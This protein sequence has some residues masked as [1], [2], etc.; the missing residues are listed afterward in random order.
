[1]CK[2]H[3]FEKLRRLFLDTLEEAPTLEQTLRLM[4]IIYTVYMILCGSEKQRIP[5]ETG[6][7]KLPVGPATA[8]K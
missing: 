3:R 5:L 8:D 6:A 4:L 2:L 1:M 7:R